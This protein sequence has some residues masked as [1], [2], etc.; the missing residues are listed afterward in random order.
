MRR[1]ALWL[2][3]ATPFAAAALLLAI[4]RACPLY[5]TRGAGLCYYD[6]DLMGGWAA[7]VTFLF[8]VDMLMLAALLCLSPGSRDRAARPRP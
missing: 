1:D 8:G 3:A 4:Q 7:G 5:V 6:A 2:L